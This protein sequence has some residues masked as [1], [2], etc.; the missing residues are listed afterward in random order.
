MAVVKGPAFSIEASGNVGAINYTRWRGMAVVRAAWTGTVPN[1]PAQMVIQ[2]YM[3]DTTQA[4]GGTLTEAE[5]QAWREYAV[6]EVRTNRLG[7]IYTPTGYQVFTQLNV[8]R[9]IFL[10]L[11]MKLPPASKG[12]SMVGAFSAIWN[13]ISLKVDVVIDGWPVAYPP[14]GCQYWKAGPFMSPGYRALENEYRLEQTYRPAAAWADGN[15]ISLRYYWY[16]ARI[17]FDSG[18]VG[19]FFYDQEFIP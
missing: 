18:Y 19:N 5:R 14:D 4:W 16:K 7:Q 2:T 15:V 17:I 9:K 8:Q 13:I 10:L 1:T 3:K 6:N 11:L 12:T